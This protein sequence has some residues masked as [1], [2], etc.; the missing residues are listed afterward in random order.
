MEVSCFYSSRDATEPPR[1]V[2]R[3]ALRKRKSTLLPVRNGKKSTRN[4]HPAEGGRKAGKGIDPKMGAR[5]SYKRYQDRPASPPRT[6][7]IRNYPACSRPRPRSRRL[8]SSR[9]RVRAPTAPS[10]RENP[11][12]RY[13]TTPTPPRAPSFRPSP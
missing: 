5:E 9:Y 7:G 13:R 4:G 2:I 3:S 1:I 10:D 8:R 11:A 6:P 12:W